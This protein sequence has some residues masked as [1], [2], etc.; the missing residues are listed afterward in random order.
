MKNFWKFTTI[1][2]AAVLISLLAMSLKPSTAEK[3][4]VTV[5]VYTTA[6]TM[7][8]T[9]M[10][11]TSSNGTENSV[12]LPSFKDKNIEE[13]AKTINAELARLINQG[14]ALKSSLGSGTTS[15]S[16]ELYIFEK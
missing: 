12:P 3:E 7:N 14:Y 6:N 1:A 5:R 15:G 4:I 2:L 8:T 16:F 10:L 13:I 11:T 9:L